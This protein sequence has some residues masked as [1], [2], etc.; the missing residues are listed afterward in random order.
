MSSDKEKIGLTLEFVIGVTLVAIGILCFTKSDKLLD[1]NT[2][3]GFILLIF[4]IYRVFR[5]L[6]NK[7][8]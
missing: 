3:G 5:F 1:T 4:G 8:K 2:I 6:K 7:D